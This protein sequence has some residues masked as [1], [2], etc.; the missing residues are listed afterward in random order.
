MSKHK[1]PSQ[2]VKES[3]AFENNVGYLM[4]LYLRCDYLLFCYLILF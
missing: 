2:Y 1:S 3:N 4:W